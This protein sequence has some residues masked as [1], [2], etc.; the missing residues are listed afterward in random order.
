[1]HYQFLLVGIIFLE[2]HRVFMLIKTKTKRIFYFR[3]YP[4]LAILNQGDS[5]IKSA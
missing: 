2:W 4:Q 3:F 1:V 5:T